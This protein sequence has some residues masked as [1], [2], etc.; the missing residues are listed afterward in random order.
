ML[1]LLVGGGLIGWNR[2]ILQRD[3]YQRTCIA[4]LKQTG[5]AMAQYIRDYDEMFPLNGN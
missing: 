1:A 2:F 5:L 4:Q 3:K